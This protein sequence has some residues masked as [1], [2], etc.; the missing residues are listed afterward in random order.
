[1][2]K[3]GSMPKCGTPRR[4]NIRRSGAGGRGVQGTELPADKGIF[5][6]VTD[7]SLSNYSED[8]R[9]RVTQSL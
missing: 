3:T 4:E 2:R 6:R 5:S 9:I 7:I 1:M 8:V